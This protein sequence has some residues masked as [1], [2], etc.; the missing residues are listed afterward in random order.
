MSITASIHTHHFINRA[1]LS[2]AADMGGDPTAQPILLLH[3]GGQTRLSWRKTLEMLVSH[4]YYVISLDARGH[5]DSQ[6]SPEGDYSLDA[7]AHD[8]LD[9]IAAVP[10]K[11]IV[12]GASMGGLTALCAVGLGGSARVHSVILVD[13]VPGLDADGSQHIVDFLQGHLDGFDSLEQVADVVSSFNPHRPR[14]K[15]IS[16]LMK[17]LRLGKNDRLYWHWDPVFFTAW[18]QADST[19]LVRDRLYDICDV[20]SVPVLLVRG[21][22]SNVVT[23]QG[24]A[25]FRKHVPHLEVFEV[26][27]AGHMITGD[28]NDIFNEGVLTFIESSLS[29]HGITA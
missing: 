17:N 15:D 10:K 7:L 13:V 29:G 28:Q 20:S 16:G 23:D 9:V 8:L 14:P 3:G 19:T 4:G 5:G 12:V 24:V 25:E 21:M 6:W 11:P 1:G 22:Y 18:D 27:G 26:G 2:L